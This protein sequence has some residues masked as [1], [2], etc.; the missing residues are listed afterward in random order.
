MAD[1]FISYSR[2]DEPFVERLREALA[3][4]EK[5]VWLDREDLG[6]AV[7][8]RREIE[9]GIESSDVF[10]FV[11]SPDSLRS[12]PCR[13]E[14]EYA[15]A[16]GK[17]IVPMLRREPEGIEVPEDLA[18]R[19]YIFVRTDG[20]FEPGVAALLAAIDDLP[21]WARDHTR[22]LERAEEWDHHQRDQSFLL[23]GSDLSE[24]ERWLAEQGAHK[25]PQ[26]TPL[27]T[28][29]LL[30]SRRGATRRQR[31][32]IGAGAVALVVSVVLGLLALLQRN[33]AQDQRD[34]A[35][36]QAQLARSR[37]LAASAVATVEADPW[38]ALELAVES[39]ETSP[40]PESTD[41]LRQA[42]EAPRESALL[43]VSD[44]QITEARFDPDSEHVLT[45]SYGSEGGGAER[46]WDLTTG[47]S[48]VVGRAA[49]GVPD[50]PP[51]TDLSRDGTLRV[52]ARGD[53]PTLSDARVGTV[54][55][56]L[57]R[58]GFGVEGIRV[59]RFSPDGRS[60]LTMSPDNIVRVWPLTLRRLD[61]D[62]VVATAIDPEGRRCLTADRRIVVTAWS[63]ATG[64]K[65]KSWAFPQF[66]LRPSFGDE[67]EIR[68]SE[69]EPRL[70]V[71]SDRATSTVD[72][73][74]GEQVSRLRTKKIFRPQLSP[75]GSLALR[76]LGPDTA[77]V[78]EASTGNRV[79]T[80]DV[81]L[82]SNA[83]AVAFSADERRV[84]SF[85]YDAP[86]VRVWD[87]DD[88][89]G[90]VALGHFEVEAV[91]LGPSAD[92]SLLAIGSN[93]STEIWDVD[94]DA[95]LRVLGGERIVNT[96]AFGADERFLV[97]GANDGR[98]RVWETATGRP[99]ADYGVDPYAMADGAL[100]AAGVLLARGF[101]GSAFVFECLACRPPAELLELAQAELGERP[102]LA[103][104]PAGP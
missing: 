48:E 79:A 101:Q 32:T 15:A 6:P 13:R 88:P 74:T 81:S 21:E 20:E 86:V 66:D 46:R 78:V 99:V 35:V 33:E 52:S 85:D 44:G 16:K 83:Q 53:T 93:T 103:R 70:T 92:G 76:P 84:A 51:D 57:N 100:S 96:V 55:L 17:R 58:L 49:S 72:V 64:A 27:Q 94:R 23:R 4:R 10:V 75:S 9:L 25:E 87:L 1:V 50:S 89:E 18:S 26:P 3:E 71:S 19:N 102:V 95:R 11:I 47:E 7:E 5:D 22:L 29:Y 54:L 90:S 77:E 59:A 65:L 24:A 31:L 73:E 45:T 37:E 14:R 68:F 40:T 104:S 67:A 97:T 80:L 82:I 61:S 34:E 12:E 2:R 41:A 38:E 36:R 63:C 28:A 8:W 30:A 60:F 98:A 69:G 42:L 43:G 91:V 39:A 56:E 62:H